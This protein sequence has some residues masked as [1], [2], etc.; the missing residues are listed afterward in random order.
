M[1]RVRVVIALIA[2]ALLVPAA[3]LAQRP[4]SKT[5][6][7][8]IVAAAVHQG[9]VSSTQ[10]ACLNVSVSTVN[11]GYA[12]LNW[13]AKLSKPCAAVAA[14]GTI[15]EQKSGASWIVVAAGSSFTCP[16]KTVPAAVAQ[17]LGICSS[18]AAPRVGRSSRPRG[19]AHSA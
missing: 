17:D 6:R 2:G 15:V 8:M 13:P 5:E 11:P 16:L 19:R 10:G 3:A 12:M 7:G 9:E 14:S 18:S 1:V 4:A